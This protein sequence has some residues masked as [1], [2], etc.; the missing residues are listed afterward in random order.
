MKMPD[1]WPVYDLMAFPKGDAAPQKISVKSRTFKSGRDCYVEYNVND[2]F[3]WL[4]IVIL[5]NDKGEPNKRRV[6][7]IPKSIAGDEN[8]GGR[9]Y[10]YPEGTKN[11]NI[12]SGQIDKLAE[13]IPEFE[14]NFC[15]SQTGKS[16]SS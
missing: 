12:R 15:L 14:D 11:H 1:N 6:Y 16:R 7:I 13:Q 9:F 3:D 4:A 2:H 5:P 10:R 8:P